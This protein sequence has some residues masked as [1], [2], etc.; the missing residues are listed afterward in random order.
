M[1]TRHVAA[2]P[3][4]LRFL[5]LVDGGRVVIVALFA[6]VALPAIFFRPTRSSRF[7]RSL[8]F[9]LVARPTAR[10]SDA[11]SRSRHVRRPYK[12]GIH[13]IVTLVAPV[14]LA[15]LIARVAFATLVALDCADGS[16]H[17]ASI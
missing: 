5:A 15:A 8:R 10:L 9:A 11:R 7:W 2:E 12:P 16:S 14:A 3:S 13:L 4:L 6:R 17:G 1:S